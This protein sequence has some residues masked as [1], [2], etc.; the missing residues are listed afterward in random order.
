MSYIIDLVAVKVPSK[1]GQAWQFLEDLRERFYDDD[2]ARAPALVKL[3]DALVERYPCKSSYKRG[4]SEL[5][6]CPWV[7]GPLLKGLASEMGMLSI[8]AEH[9][10]EVLPFVVETALALG[11]VVMDEQADKIYR[12]GKRG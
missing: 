8:S 9:V 3:H 10:Q 4:S 7:E 12:P 2:G 1:T 6:N 5:K 11:V